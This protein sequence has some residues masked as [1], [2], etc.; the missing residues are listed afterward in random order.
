MVSIGQSYIANNEEREANEQ[1]ILKEVR[2]KEAKEMDSLEIPGAEEEKE[3]E[4][5]SSSIMSFAR[6]MAKGMKKQIVS[7]LSSVDSLMDESPLLNPRDPIPLFKEE[8]QAISLM[9]AFCPQ[10]STPDSQ[11]GMALAQGFSGCLPHSSPPVL[12]KGGVARGGCLPNLGMEAFVP[13][14]HVIRKLVYQNAQEY[15]DVLCQC[16]KLTIDDL[17]GSLSNQVLE[18]DNVIRLVQW[19]VKFMAKE[20][21][22]AHCSAT[23]K[24][25]IRFFDAKDSSKVD[26]FQNYVYFVTNS[27]LNDMPVPEAVLPR[28]LHVNIGKA[29]P[30]GWFVDLP[31]DVWAQFIAHSSCM[32]KGH[33][34]DEKVRVA[35]LA[36]LCKD[37]RALSEQRKTV[38]GLQ[39]K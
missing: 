32:T 18:R 8:R 25:V 29:L 36:I 26:S 1:R 7:V 31:I 9:Q 10:Q 15:H 38:F 24:D 3:P 11:V 13:Q 19:W 16:K 5:T 20:P 28:D 17:L 34:D 6:F 33:V 4:T 12:T 23:L 30:K 21:H 22:F 2:R 27:N 35:A 14:S 39:V 37:W